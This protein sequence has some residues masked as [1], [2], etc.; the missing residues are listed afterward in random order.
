MIQNNESMSIRRVTMADKSIVTE[1]LARCFAEDP[2]VCWLLQEC[3][4]PSKMSILMSYVFEETLRKGEIYINDEHTAVSL[5][6]SERQGKITFHFFYSH[7]SLLLKIG[8]RSIMRML[9]ME[10][11][12]HKLYPK[13]TPYYHLYLLAVAPERQG[14]GLASKMLKPV[15]EEKSQQGIPAFLETANLTNV[16]IYKKKGF[17]T[18]ETIREGEHELSVMLKE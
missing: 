8:P 14:L 13:K 17:R 9:R 5:W 2:H 18:I 1:I 12:V 15:L 11:K 4:N 10:G 16:E 3:E 7:I 6:D